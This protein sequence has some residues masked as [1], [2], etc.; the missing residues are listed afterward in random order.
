MAGVALGLAAGALDVGVS[1]ASAAVAQAVPI[2]TFESPVY[3]ATA[4]G[5]PDLL[6]VVERAGQIQVL[7]D[8]QRLA[9]PFLDIRDIVL[10]MPDAGAGGEQGLLSVAFPPDYAQTRRFYVAFTN[11]NGDVEV[12]EFQRTAGNATLASPASR[13][14]VLVIPHR[15]A[16]NHNGGQLQ[17]GPDRLLYLSTGDGGGAAGTLPG[18]NSRNLENLLGKILRID[19]SPAGARR[20]RVP[21][22][23]P[24]VNRAGRDEIYAYGLRNPWRFSF[25][26]QRMAIAD[27]GA[28][29]KEEV[30]ILYRSSVAGTNFGWPQYEGDV[31]FD[32]AR[33]GPDTPKP[34]IFTYDHTDSRCAVL[35]GYI[36]RDPTLT[37]L[38]GRYLYG[39]LCTGE[40]RSF[41]P[42][43]STQ[44]AMRDE[45]TGIVLPRISSFGQ[46][47]DGQIYLVELAGNVS[48]L[49]ALSP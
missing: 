14:V 6:F 7:Q 24:F 37:A 27:V 4:P 25:D 19:P 23:N 45:P 42:N 35:G 29:V 15:V 22:T 9:Q 2:G 44:R 38:N 17:F 20:Y 30:N 3:V 41:I 10:G 47:F 18:E 28:K 48:R 16:Q 49:E 46:G 5:E 12:D 1:A 32:A 43:V 26:D 33:P 39:D 40:V 34:P 31:F 8:E 13:R 11:S 21:A 36:V